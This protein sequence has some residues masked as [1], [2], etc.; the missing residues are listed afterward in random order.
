VSS[1]TTTSKVVVCSVSGLTS[2]AAAA[3]ATTVAISTYL[4]D[5]SVF[6]YAGNVPF[7]AIFGGTAASPSISPNSLMQVILK[8]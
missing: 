8:G 7:P 5:G 2:P 3:A 4:S 6:D 1:A